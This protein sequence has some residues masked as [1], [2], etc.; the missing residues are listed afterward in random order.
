[1][2]PWGLKL[3][4]NGDRLDLKV[5]MR[6]FSQ[7]LARRRSVRRAYARARARARVGSSV[8]CRLERSRHGALGTKVDP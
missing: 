6:F 2:L 1:M 4:L 8:L 5:K 7:M 3:P